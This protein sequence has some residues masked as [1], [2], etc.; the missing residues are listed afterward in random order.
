MRE[1]MHMAGVLQGYAKKASSNAYKRNVET[2]THAAMA[3]NFDIYIGTLAKAQP[4]HYHHV[5]EYATGGSGYQSI[6]KLPFKL[7]DHKLSRQGSGG[8][9]A[10]WDWRIAKVPNP[11]YRQRRSAS[12]GFDDIRNLSTKDYRRLLAKSKNKRHTFRMK[13]PMLEYGIKRIVLPRGKRLFVPM[14]GAK[15]RNSDGGFFFSTGL[16]AGT[17][18]PG[19]TTGYFTAAWTT[20]WG[21]IAPNDFDRVIGKEIERDSARAIKTAMAAGTNTRRRV[22]SFGFSAIADNKV[23][24]QRGRLQAMA[25]MG[26]Q[27]KSMTKI[28]DNIWRYV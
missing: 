8:T 17:Q 6:G 26:E 16:V 12:I 4:E 5:Y 25:A 10:S 22:R 18:Q 23:A 20:Y 15:M 2:A 14:K 11:T 3:K 21:Q 24:F 19:K 27:E 1:G 7:W 9:V 13:A 28:S